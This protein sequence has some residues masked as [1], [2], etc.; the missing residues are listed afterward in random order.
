[1]GDKGLLAGSAGVSPPALPDGASPR[2]AQGSARG[3]WVVGQF[4]AVAASLS[5][6]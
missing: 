6:S 3:L 4:D 1:M 5:V 2:G